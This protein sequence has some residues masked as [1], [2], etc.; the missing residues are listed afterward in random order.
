MRRDDWETPAEVYLPLFLSFLFD[1]DAAANA[2]NSKTRNYLGPGGLAEDALQEDWWQY[3]LKI[4]CNPPYRNITPWLQKAIEACHHGSIVVMLLPNSRDTKWFHE[5]IIPAKRD[6]YC[7]TYSY[8]G[9]VKF[10]DPTGDNR[11]APK[12]GNML[13]VF[14]PPV[15]EGWSID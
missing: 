15:L 8:K 11:K 9:R 3:G 5:I 10:D 4:W 12:Q 6:G 14:T 1:L 2:S 7:Q 13:V